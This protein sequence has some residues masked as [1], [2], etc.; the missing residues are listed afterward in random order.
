MLPVL[1]LRVDWVGEERTESSV[2]REA[3][4]LLYG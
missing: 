3:A 1:L 4:R 2:S